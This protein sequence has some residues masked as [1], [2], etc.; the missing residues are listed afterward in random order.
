MGTADPAQYVV[1]KGLNPPSN[2][3]TQARCQAFAAA[4]VNLTVSEMAHRLL[5]R[6]FTCVQSN[7]LSHL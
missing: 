6:C 4:T 2:I 5:A 1:L 7:Y 3:Y